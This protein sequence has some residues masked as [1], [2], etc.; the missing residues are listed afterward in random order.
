M[1]TLQKREAKFQKINRIL[2]LFWYLFAAALV[3][4]Y[5]AR[6]D[7][8][9]LTI[10]LGTLLVPPA[11]ALGYRISG[12]RRVHQMD[13]LILSFVFLA[14]PLGACLDFYRILPGF[15]KIAHTL[16]GAFVGLLCLALYYRLKPGHAV[17][18]NDA[19]LAMA[20]VFFG[21]MAVAGLWE[22]GEYLLS[23]IVKIDLQR[24]LSTTISDTIWD[25]VVALAGTAALLPFVRRLCHG[26]RDLVTGAVE[27]FVEINLKE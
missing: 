14:Y 3:I 12:L 20:F 16:S 1:E 27:A 19:A 22:I 25:M 17:E 24:V 13:F 26:K 21:S 4:V 6:K 9:H 5:A 10:S 7:G 2:I 8:Y 15:D 18:A 23:A 11:L